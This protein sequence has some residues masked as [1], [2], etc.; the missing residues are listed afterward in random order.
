MRDRTPCE[1]VEDP[2]EQPRGCPLL[3]WGADGPGLAFFAEEG[4]PARPEP[5]GR[6][7]RENGIR[8]KPEEAGNVRKTPWKSPIEYGIGVK[9]EK[10]PDFTEKFHY[11][12]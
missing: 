8:K 9:R 5:S 6:I 10:T 1:T 3:L 7:P 2:W 4:E 11:I 12:W